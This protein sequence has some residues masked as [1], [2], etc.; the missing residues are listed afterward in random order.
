VVEARRGLFPARQM[1]LRR[2]RVA[3]EGSALSRLVMEDRDL[4]S[5]GLKRTKRT[6]SGWRARRSILKQGEVSSSNN[7]LRSK[8]LLLQ[9]KALRRLRQTLAERRPLQYRRAGFRRTSGTS[10]LRRYS[11][12]C[13]RLV[14]W[15]T[16]SSGLGFFECLLARRLGWSSGIVQHHFGRR[17]APCFPA[18]SLTADFYEN[19]RNAGIPFADMISSSMNLFLK[20]HAIISLNFRIFSGAK[21]R[22]M[23][24]PHGLD[25]YSCKLN[26]RNLQSTIKT[27]Q[28]P[29]SNP[30]PPRKA[31]QH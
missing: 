20:R 27:P 15:E 2:G 16:R 5:T 13:L 12:M 17:I 21:R 23:S 22:S 3:A 18:L 30:K 4:R 7:R 10:S 1:K 25:I 11:H 6:G 26:T 8:K 29:T 19:H 14:R 9:Q 28:T 24:I 31:H